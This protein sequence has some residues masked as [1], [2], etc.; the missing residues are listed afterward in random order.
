M[1]TLVTGA[2]GHVGGELV[3]RLAAIGSHQVRAMTRRPDAAAA[4]TMRATDGVEVVQGDADD[5]DGLAMVFRGVDRAFLM[6]AEPTDHAEPRQLPRLVHAARRAG[7]R[8]VVLL[9]VYS[10]GGGAD[11]IGDW[12]RRLEDAVTGS[13]L[14]WTLLR[15][16]RFMSNALH[17]APAIRR[18]PDRHGV[19]IPFARRP[20]AA[21]DPADVAAVAAEVL[22]APAGHLGAA[23]QLS[24][25]ELLTPAE[26][27]A[28]IAEL[29]GRPL[30]LLE[31]PPAQVR[32]DLAR[33]GASPAVVD[34]ILARAER[35][36]EGS[37][38]LP[39]VARLLGRPPATFAQ[40]ATRH[41]ASFQSDPNQ[42][43]GARP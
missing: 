35:S 32:A 20:A 1:P 40:W 37:A 6:S 27:L 9:S 34:A 18:A 7:V 11:V 42:F 22:T 16:G 41:L 23:Y 17:W 12:H 30:R 19:S 26:E 2:T 29:L 14:G 15:P 36:D 13:G 21:I 31:P 4:A 38:L 33:G 24:G 5:P 43:E 10:G 3:A 28:V 25:P 8:Q 39:T